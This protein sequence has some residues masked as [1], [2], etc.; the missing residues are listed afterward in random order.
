MDIENI[1]KQLQEAFDK[2][3]TERGQKI[4]KEL[5]DKNGKEE[6]EN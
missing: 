2:A 1:K 3:K 4:A 5:G 6:K